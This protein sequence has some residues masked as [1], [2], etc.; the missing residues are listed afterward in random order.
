VPRKKAATEDGKT[1]T[2]MLC[3]DLGGTVIP[4]A[5]RDLGTK[6][7]VDFLGRLLGPRFLGSLPLPSE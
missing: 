1:G 6:K 4:S 2:G 5:A 7:E 3:L